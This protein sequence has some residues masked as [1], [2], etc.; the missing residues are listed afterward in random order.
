MRFAT[1]CPH[2]TSQHY[3][4]GLCE[5]C[6]ERLPKNKAKNQQQAKRWKTNLRKKL[7]KRGYTLY[8]RESNLRNL[9]HLTAEQY[10]MLFVR[11]ANLCPCGV[12]LTE[13]V[14]PNVDHN[15][16]C[17][18]GRKSCGKCVRGILCRRCNRVLGLLNEN[19]LLLPSYLLEYLK[20]YAQL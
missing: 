14:I 6:Y 17:C 4:F 16:S 9:Y 5:L 11:Q 7:G 12:L 15:H 2:T 20:K 1:K 8:L 19:P 10:S 18:P 13:E 3:A